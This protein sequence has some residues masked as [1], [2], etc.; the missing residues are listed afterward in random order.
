MRF[1]PARSPVPLVASLPLLGVAIALLANVAAAQQA[2]PAIASATPTASVDSLVTVEGRVRGPDGLAIASAEVTITPKPS[3]NVVTLARRLY[4]DDSGA[5]KFPALPRGPATLAVRRVGFKPV[6]IETSLPFPQTM[7]VLL[8]STAHALS[9]VVVQDRRRN[10]DGPLAD[11]NRRRDFGIGRFITAGQIDSRNAMRTTDLLR[12]IP[13][14]Q[15]VS[16]IR[17]TTLRLRGS[18]CDPLVWIDGSPALAGYFDIDA[19]SP[20]S[21]SGIEIYNGVSE[22]PVELRGPRGEERCGV[23]AVWSRMPERRPRKSKNKPVTAEELNALI[24]SAT[25]YTAEQVDRAAQ[26]DSEMPVEAY[27]PDSLKQNKV[28]GVAVVEF[29]VDTVGRVETET[30]SVVLASHPGFARA[31]REAVF[32]AHFIPALLRGRPVRQIVQLPMRFQAAAGKR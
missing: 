13:G 27:Y 12:S 22:V 16:G 23:I 1:P 8:E 21:L 9:P 14:V 32:S 30:I 10:Y 3:G 31:A 28:S 15:V 11:F 2:T 17:G 5:F 26:V 29:V 4:S 19:F 25:V 6:S 7:S 18:R 20:N 24:A